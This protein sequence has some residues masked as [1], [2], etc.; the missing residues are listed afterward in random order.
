MCIRDSTGA[1]VRPEEDAAAVVEAFRDGVIT[2][3]QP[4]LALLLDN[5]PS[6]P[7][8]YTHLDVYKRQVP[9]RLSRPSIGMES[10]SPIYVPMES[11]KK[12]GRDMNHLRAAQ[13]A[14][15]EAR[16]TSLGSS[17]G[18]GGRGL[19]LIHI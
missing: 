18:E 14:T 8:S 2:T 11:A 17:G 19:S 6:N 10:S 3:G 4:P 16:A 13:A 5:R 7:V 9:F 12:R 15:S 1:C